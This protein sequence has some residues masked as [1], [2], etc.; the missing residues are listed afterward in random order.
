MRT[1]LRGKFTLLFLMLGLLLAIPAIALADNVK[2]DVIAGGNDT[3]VIGGSTT[4]KYEIQQT[5]SG[6]LGGCD[7]TTA[8]PVTVNINAPTGVTASPSSLSFSSCGTQ[9]SV[10]FSSNT[11][12]NYD[13]TVSTVDNV[14]DYNVTPAKFTL[15]VTAPPPPTNTA[16]TLTLPSNPTA[17][18]TGPS[19]AAVSFNATANDA[20]D[21]AL[22]PTC[23]PASGSTFALGST[24]VNCSV[25]D[26]G[27]LTT[28][29]FFAVSVQDTTKPVIAA[30][31]DVTAEAT[32]PD[33]ANVSYTSPGTT[34]A[35][36]GPGTATCL[37]ASDTKFAL[38]ANTV[39]CNATDAAGNQA[40]ATTFKVTVADTTK[41]ELTL[42]EN[43]TEEATG[44]SGA[45]VSFN[46]TATDA[47]DPNVNVTCD[48][49]S[50]ST[51][52]LGTTTVDCKATDA[53]NNTATG[54]F[55][56]KVQD[57]TPPKL[58]LPDNI[59]E[60]ATGPNGNVVTYN[61]T[62]SDLVS[63]SVNVNCAPASGST[64]AIATTTVDCSATDAANNE[65]TG[66]FTVK[67]QDTIAPS[68]F[69]FVGNIN[70]GD[71]FFFGD[72]PD[73]PTCTAT[74]GG[75]G[76]NSAGCVVSGYSTAVGTH[77]LKAT[78]TDKAGN[79]ATKEITYTVKAWTTKGFYQPVDMST[80]TT[81]VW[82]T[83]KGG[84]T[85][86]L[87]FELFKGTTE[88]TDPANVKPLQSTKVSCSTGSA[89]ED[90]IE[91]VATGGTSL[92]Y[93]STGGQFIYNWKT[94][95]GA[96]TCYKVTLTA[97][98]NSTT[99]TAYFKMK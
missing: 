80:A 20:Q 98:D 75:S 51:F 34:D 63:G 87:K 62:A 53:A 41:P 94:P 28:S 89:T 26:S 56:V 69:Q 90:A 92:R 85:V 59:T 95:T 40:T 21:G 31:G 13:I 91:T 15:H 96:N 39:T 47:V 14:G 12:G 65:A 37:P 48:P 72:V 58:T 11:A 68:N 19:G 78:A 30:H 25:T 61:A 83:V 27:G 29:G 55:T 10:A 50:G 22:T 1:M 3:I 16:P 57:T 33:G 54:S 64:F 60:E 77:T 76:L 32:G 52:A 44:P 79:T 9:K 7:A 42:P 36:D 46:A 8:S 97:Q 38:G 5:G 86:P 6:N 70:D 74:D 49:A 35:V 45:A 84:S 99:I 88:L 17:E 82:N 4:I 81:T 43:I 18:A 2:N 67:V 73:Q 24:Q 71:S 93:D 66:S 23:T